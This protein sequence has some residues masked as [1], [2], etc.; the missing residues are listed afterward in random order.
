VNYYLDLGFVA[1]PV[2][3]LF[4]DVAGSSSTNIQVTTTWFIPLEGN[5]EFAGFVDLWLQDE[6]DSDHTQLVLLCEPQ[7][8]YNANEYLAI[9]SEVEIS[10]NFV[11]GADGI[12]ALPTVGLRWTF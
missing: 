10:D 1:L 12:Q 5:I 7:I 2:D 9:G 4:R 8:W 6:T 11:F 3:I